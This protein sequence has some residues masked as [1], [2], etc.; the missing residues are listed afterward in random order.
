MNKNVFEDRIKPIL[1]YIGTIGAILTIMAYFLVIFVLINGFEYHQTIQT[2]TVACVSAGIGLIVMT[3]LK[4]QGT[5]FA[6]NLP[7]NVEIIKEYY[8]TKTHDKKPHS[9]AYY[10]ITTTIK[11]I[12]SKGLSIV[13]STTGLV[14]ICIE[15]SQDYRLLLLA[16]VNLILFVCFG[17]LA[18]VKSYD[19]YNNVFVEYMKEQIKN[20][21][22]SNNC[23]SISGSISNNKL[24]KEKQ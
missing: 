13:V 23:T 18:L 7:Q 24:Y 9:M 15:G 22:N 1:T 16:V 20:G 8:S 4:I 19:Y 10:W 6:R 2:I 11:D 3:F 12:I 21:S 5:D 17:L 14:Y